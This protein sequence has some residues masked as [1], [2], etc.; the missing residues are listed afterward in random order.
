MCL[1]TQG[2][3]KGCAFTVGGIKKLYATNLDWIDSW[4]EATDET[5]SAITMVGFAITDVTIGA[6]AVFEAIGHDFKVGDLVWINGTL[7][8]LTGPVLG[9]H[10]ITAVTSTTFTIGALTT[11]GTF[12]TDAL[13][14][15]RGWFEFQFD[16]STSSISGP[17]TVSNGNRF[18]TQTAQVQI[19]PANNDT[20]K[21]IRQLALGYTVW[22]AECND[23]TIKILFDENGGQP[24]ATEFT[25]GV[26]AGDFAGFNVTVTGEED[27]PFRIYD[28]LAPL[29]VFAL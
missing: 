16:K 19:T 18:F 28:G 1:I 13:T 11:G 17:L 4:T 22:A 15:D 3:A 26:A 8:T 9:Q 21:I 27:D 6:A 7:T 24:S 14:A 12:T 2:H 23:G 10:T 25:S 20:R 29:P 5:Y